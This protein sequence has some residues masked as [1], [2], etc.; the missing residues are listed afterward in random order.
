MSNLVPDSQEPS[1]LTPADKSDI[2]SD[3]LVRLNENLLNTTKTNEQKEILETMEQAFEIRT[4]ASSLEFNEILQRVER[5]KIIKIAIISSELE[6]AT[7]RNKIR[8]ELELKN[9]EI[10]QKKQSAQLDILEARYKI[11]SLRTKQILGFTSIPLFIVFGAYLYLYSNN[12]SLGITMIVLGL[13]G[14]LLN[15]FQDIIKLLGL[16]NPKDN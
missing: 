8:D 1:D 11:S 16:L 15:S 13:G 10:D 4:K 14:A 3:F 9:I 12:F 6:I 7:A 5:D 2:L